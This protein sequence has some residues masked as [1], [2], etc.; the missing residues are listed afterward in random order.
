MARVYGENGEFQASLSGF[1]K[2]S[3]KRWNRFIIAR[4]IGTSFE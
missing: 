3:S 1:M 4:L 2:S